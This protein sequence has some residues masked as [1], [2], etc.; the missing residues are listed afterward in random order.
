MLI[1]TGCHR[2]IGG[3]LSTILERR[4]YEVSRINRATTIGQQPHSNARLQCI[5]HA[6]VYLQSNRPRTAIDNNIL[7][8]KAVKAFA[9]N[10]QVPV[11]H[12]SSIVAQG[13]SQENEPHQDV[14][15]NSPIGP[16]AN[17]LLRAETLLRSQ[18]S[19]ESDIFRLAVPYG[20]NS[21]FEQAYRNIQ[22][23]RIRPLFENLQLTFIH[24]DDVADLIELRM[25]DRS[26]GSIYGHLSDGVVRN[27]EE[28][29]NAMELR[30]PNALRLPIPL[31]NSI[32]ALT[33]R[34]AA[35]FGTWSM[36][37]HFAHASNWTS[38]G[39]ENTSNI[40]FSPRVNWRTYLARLNPSLS[41]DS[42]PLR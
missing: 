31:S 9:R 13:P 18:S 14:N 27:S 29:L 16:I 15:P 38:R 41:G 30:G 37:R 21:G 8:T 7:G 1:I 32:W 42:T 11:I 12:L 10:T 35:P 5:I 22:R 36:L 23:S 19:V 3:T 20:Y 34:I 26:Q 2:H 4:G 33:E 40:P 28:F 17:S 39:F 25:A 6:D 24:L